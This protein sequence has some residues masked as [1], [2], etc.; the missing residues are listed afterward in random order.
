MTITK[1]TFKSLLAGAFL[2]CAFSVPAA[3]AE[4]AGVKFEETV[5]QAGKEIKLNGVGMRTKF[6]L[7]IYA[8]GMYLPE[9]ATT[10]E[11]VLKMDGPRRMSL[12]MMRDVSSDEFGSAF[13]TGLNDNS[14][15]AEKA[16]IIAQI[17]KFGEMFALLESIKKGDELQ[18]NWMPGVGTMSTLNGKKIGEVLPDIA[19]YNAVTRIW[20]GEKPVDRSLKVALLGGKK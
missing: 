16:K 15:S 4:I 11:E 20:L 5:K 10:T 13:I 17:S 12:V 18:L 1:M 3:A 2:A 6:F 9:K 14:N 8:T 19:F 7:K